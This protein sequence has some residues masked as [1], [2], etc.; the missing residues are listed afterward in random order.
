MCSLDDVVYSTR[1]CDQY[2][3]DIEIEGTEAYEYL[4]SF[5]N[6]SNSNGNS[7]AISG[8]SL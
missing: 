7:I 3:E 2:R 5:W 4:T 1:C 6:L 8:T